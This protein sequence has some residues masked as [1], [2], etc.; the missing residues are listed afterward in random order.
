MPRLCRFALAGL[1]VA[2]LSVFALPAFAADDSGGAAE[3]SDGPDPMERQLA[4]LETTAG[5]MVFELFADRAPET[6]ANFIRLIGDDFYDGQPF[7]RV[8]AGHVIQ[9]GD[10]GENDQPTV[11]GEFGVEHLEGTLGLARDTDPDSGSTEIYVCL[12]PRPHLDGH[13]AAFG[14]LVEGRDVLHAIGSAPVTEKFLEGDI[15]FHEPKEPVTIVDARL[16]IEPADDAP[17]TP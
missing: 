3:G 10:G 13:Y 9:A 2:L 7:Y 16:R 8:V 15:A 12:E 4:V 14:Q 11:K 5:T 17:S 6:V 1:L